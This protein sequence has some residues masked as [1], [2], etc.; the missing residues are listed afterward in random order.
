[1]ATNDEIIRLIMQV[2]NQAELEKARDSV[3]RLEKQL[4]ALNPA[5]ANFAQQQQQIGAQL[6]G[7]RKRIEELEGSLHKGRGGM[8]QFMA[9]ASYMA[10]DLQYLGSQGIRPLVNNIGP[11]LAQLGV[12]GSALATLGTATYILARNWRSVTAGLRSDLIEQTGDA[13][14]T[15]TKRMEELKQQTYLTR[16]EM[17]EMANLKEK[18]AGQ[19]AL[20]KGFSAPSP[21]SGKI[22]GAVADITKEGQFGAVEGALQQGLFHEFNDNKLAK[23][24]DAA[25][26]GLL[27]EKNGNRVK[28]DGQKWMLDA[29]YRQRLIGLYTQQALPHERNLLLA[30]LGHGDPK[31]L[32]RFGGLLRGAG[33]AGGPMAAILR[34]LQD[35]AQKPIGPQLPE[36][37]RER[38]AALG[39]QRNE[40]LEDEAHERADMVALEEKILHEQA[41]LF[42]RN[43]DYLNQERKT[44]SQK[45]EE[46][47]DLAKKADLERQLTDLHRQARDHEEKRRDTLASQAERLFGPILNDKIAEAMARG[48]TDQNIGEAIRRQFEALGLPREIAATYARELVKATRQEWRNAA[49]QNRLIAMNQGPAPGNPLAAQALGFFNMMA[50]QDAA[51]NNM[52]G[53]GMNPAMFARIQRQFGLAGP[54]PLAEAPGGIGPPAP[55]RRL[56]NMEVERNRARRRAQ[57]NEL[58]RNRRQK[59]IR[60]FQH[61]GEMDRAERMG[62]FVAQNELGQKL[63]R[64]IQIGEDQ[65]QKSNVAQLA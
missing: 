26:Q 10:D 8:A 43:Q 52:L 27:T 34:R 13:V 3:Q 36:A 24:R 9:Q 37:E 29:G 30:Q 16:Q 40:W 64:L 18:I 56:H 60:G 46:E 38:A 7:T 65:L 20:D 54:G 6:L 19:Q 58:E 48:L 45:I 22:A 53:A 47:R 25:D 14:D 63:D 39:Q 49:M 62:G 31:A 23:I 59:I 51:L 2:Q 32:D 61:G 44:L 1:M 5:S 50:A 12:W 28:F 35:A 41:E 57:A 4:L 33:I 15:L 21:E 55:R 42:N 11:L 17:Q